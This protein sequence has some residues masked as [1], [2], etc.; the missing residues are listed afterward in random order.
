MKRKPSH[1]DI[2]QKLNSIVAENAEG[3][4]EVGVTEK[5][6]LSKLEA[7]I[8]GLLGWLEMYVGKA[9]KPEATLKPHWGS[10]GIQYCMKS[11]RCLCFLFLPP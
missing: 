2:T 7:R 4:V 5:H 11:M 8:P 10:K 3:L 1:Q 9:P 6:T